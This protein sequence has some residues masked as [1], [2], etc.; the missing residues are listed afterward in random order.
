MIHPHRP[1]IILALLAVVAT[2]CEEAAQPRDLP[3]NM[4]ATSPTLN[5]SALSMILHLPSEVKA[6]EPVPLSLVVRNTS[7]QPVYLE[8]GDST[9]TFDVR[10]MDQSGKTVWRRM[11]ERESLAAL[12]EQ[13]LAPG[14]EVQFA[15]TWD[16]RSNAGARV[17]QGKYEVH[18][19]LDAQGDRDLVTARVHLV[20]SDRLAP[21]AKP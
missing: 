2:G 18:G 14:E 10:V 16:Q 19:T 1:I 17:P 4:P 13:N 21:T 7:Q 9:T 20:I 6:G 3:P 12:H 5:E 11:H 8:T 15:D